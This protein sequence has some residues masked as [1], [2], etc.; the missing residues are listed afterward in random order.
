MPNVPTPPDF[1]QWTL[2]RHESLWLNR[3]TNLFERYQIHKNDSKNPFWAGHVTFYKDKTGLGNGCEYNIF[4]QGV[5]FKLWGLQ[6][7][8]GQP[9]GSLMILA[10][11]VWNYFSGSQYFP[12]MQGIK[13]KED[14]SNAPFSAMCIYVEDPKTEQ[15]IFELVVPREALLLPPAQK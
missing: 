2:E 3:K 14:K 6:L 1:S 9:W 15:S 4:G 8:Q 13:P 10:G 12:G 11:G 5:V 7:K